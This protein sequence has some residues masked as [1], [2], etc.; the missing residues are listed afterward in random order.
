MIAQLR[1][2]D[3]SAS[4]EV[5]TPER[6]IIDAVAQSLTDS[7]IDL[8]LLEGGLDVEAKFGS[9]LDRFLALFGFNRQT[10]TFSKGFVN[11][12]RLTPSSF[13][14]RIPAGTQIISRISGVTAGN[15]TDITF[16]T[17]LEVILEPPNLSV[18][19]P[20]RATIPGTPGNVSANTITIF[21]GNPTL[22]ITAVTNQLATL[23]GVDQEDDDEFKT[24]FRNTV[25]RNLAG[26]EDQYLALAAAT[27][28]TKKVNVIGPISRYREYLQ[29]PPVDDTQ[30]YTSGGVAYGAGNGLAAQYTSAL[31]TLPYGK[32]VYTNIP[33]FVSNG[34]TGPTSVF[35]RNDTDFVLN[36]TAAAKDR[37]DT[38]RLRN[39]S[40]PAGLD[41]NTDPVGQL[42][43]NLVFTN[44][45]TGVDP[46]VTALI[47]GQVV[48]FE[49]SYISAVSRNDFVRGVTNAVDVFIDGDNIVQA[50]SI[51]PRP[52][53]TSLFV[54]DVTNK[55][56][57]N[58]YR[59]IG[60]PEQRP[61]LGNIFSPMFNQPATDVPSSIIVNGA[62]TNTY[63]KD[64]HYYAVEDVSDIGGTIRSRNGIE[65]NMGVV[66]QISGDAITG[67]FAGS[68]ITEHASSVI[69]PINNYRYDANI[70]DLQVALEGAKQV[71]TDVLAHKSRKR[72]F[73]LDISVMYN[74]G[75]S[76]A[77]VNLSIS[78]G[79][80][81][82]FDSLF[83]GSV[84]QLSDLLQVVHGVPGVD[85]VR[86]ST[87]TPQGTVTDR[88]RET[89][90][91]GVPILAAS[92]TRK[93]WP[94][95]GRSTPEVQQ[96][97]VTGAPT[98][99]SFVLKF[100]AA[101]TSALAYNI[102]AAT[103]QTAV[104]TLTGDA[105]LTVTGTGSIVTPFLITFTGTA[106]HNLITSDNSGLT[107]GATVI[108]GDFFL[109]DNELPSLPSVAAAGDTVAGLIIRTRA[110][111]TYIK[112]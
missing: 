9:G 4:A 105:T 66:G 100:G 110:Q 91:F 1:L 68:F 23:G 27:A 73:R 5:G 38:Y 94:N 112:R 93:Q 109:R 85:N 49:Y 86:W 67:P 28:F 83:F 95:A 111:N 80:Q 43:P 29:V 33:Y 20:V 31:S 70:V 59:R 62:V 61:V 107:G 37:G 55:F 75:V 22:G 76:V 44:V 63:Y 47:P 6:K 96:L 77:G 69:V 72:Y 108:S 87:D 92:V 58:N 39:T 3:P 52:G 81:Q 56:H 78:D 40:P 32:Y 30:P 64:I 8:A 35:Y 24:R 54:N 99:G 104:R 10:A 50:S 65:W 102:S 2:L 18:V 48:L 82:H 36:T 14:I 60:L 88:L 57:Y 71:T 90:K 16:T 17:T 26:T 45:Y 12:S 106:L 51:I 98:G 89:D 7:Q 84:I 103:L 53:T 15:T 11:F 79:V 101:V 41:P 13:K 46:T 19:A 97:I 25:F 21:G 42:Q 34:V 74:P